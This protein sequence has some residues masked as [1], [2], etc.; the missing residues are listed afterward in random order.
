MDLAIFADH[1][2]ALRRLVGGARNLVYGRRGA[3]APIR[4]IFFD[5]PRKRQLRIQPGAVQ[6]ASTQLVFAQDR[7]RR[8]DPT[9]AAVETADHVAAA[10]VVLKL[11]EHGTA[12]RSFGENLNFASAT[13]P[14]ES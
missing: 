8:L 3:H 11:D 10:R 13:K 7:E 12:I 9:G 6:I 5:L 1:L 4:Q 14:R 2:R